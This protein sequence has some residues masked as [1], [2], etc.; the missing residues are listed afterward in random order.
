VLSVETDVRILYD[1]GESYIGNES[2][3]DIHQQLQFPVST[4][5]VT[6]KERQ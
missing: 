4:A 2:V 5:E 3:S 6:V 1:R